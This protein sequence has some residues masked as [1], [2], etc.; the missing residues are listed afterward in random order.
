[1]NS[2]FRLHSRAR[3]V[4]AQ[5][6]GTP[7]VAVNATSLLSPLT[8]I[9][10]Y[11]SNLMQ[12]I[13]RRGHFDPHY[14]YGHGWGRSLREVPV[15]GINRAKELV[16]RVVPNPHEVGRQIQV[17]QFR[18]GLRK[19]PCDLYHDPNYLPLEFPGPIVNT[20]HDLSF[21][22]YPETHPAIRIRF[23]EKYLPDALERCNCVITDSAFVRDEVLSVFGVPRDKIYPIHLGVS[24]AYHPRP[25]EE[26]RAT[27]ERFELSHGQYVLAVG[28]LEPRKNLIQGLRSFHRLP[29]KLRE[30]MPFVIV[31]MKGWLTAGIEAEIDSLASRG[32]VRSLGYL[33]NEDL[34]QIY[35]GAT[36]LIYPSVYEGFGLPALEAMASGIPVITSNRSS[37][38]EV[39]GEVGIM[40]DPGDEHGFTEAMRRI[41]ED[42]IERAVRSAAGLERARHFTWAKCA[43]ETER[44]YRIALAER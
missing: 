34:L 1:M 24:P 25:R 22:R 23:L 38:P 9:G 6:P 8:G 17:F 3:Q 33:P 11:T 44:V 29:E 5:Q 37:L 42:P 14:F 40:V 35:A 27:L 12:A 19:L 31:G 18:R 13:S 4:A 32:Q 28:T 10:Q 43:E 15:R 7:R 21:V 26:T 36:M 39:V 41:A 30:A 20:V 2:T 16:K